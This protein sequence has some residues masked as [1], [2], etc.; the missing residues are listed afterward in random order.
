M[1]TTIIIT[2]GAIDKMKKKG[3]NIKIFFGHILK[4]IKSINTEFS[5]PHP[6]KGG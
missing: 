5:T 6:P 2:T 3:L 1:E 4:L